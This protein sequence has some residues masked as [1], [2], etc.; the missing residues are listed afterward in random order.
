MLHRFFNT[1]YGAH[2]WPSDYFRCAPELAG[3]FLDIYNDISPNCSI[4]A[5][6][7]NSGKLMGSCFRC[8]ASFKRL[9]G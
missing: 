4:A 5:F 2:G 6:D 3:I 1:W 7:S 9:T 8:A